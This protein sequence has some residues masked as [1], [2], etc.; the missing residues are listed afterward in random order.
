MPKAVPGLKHFEEGKKEAYLYVMIQD[1]S[2]MGMIRERAKLREQ[3][4][5]TAK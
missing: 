2:L 1:L 3:P 4:K 5:S